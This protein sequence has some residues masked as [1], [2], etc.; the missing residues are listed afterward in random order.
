MI[1][2]ID[3]DHRC[4]DEGEEKLMEICKP[5]WPTRYLRAAWA[6]CGL[7]ILSS[8]PLA[9]TQGGQ[10][11][12]RPEA[13]ETI[14]L[15]VPDV[16]AKSPEQ[17][18]AL[19]EAIGLFNQVLWEDLKFSGYF[20]MAGKSFY[21]PTP[22]TGPEDLD[23]DAWKAIPFSV[24]YTSVG[25]LELTGGILRAELRVV[26]ME[27]QAMAFGKAIRGDTDQVR[28]IAHRWADEV[29]YQLT[30]GESKGIA[31]TK[32]SYTAASGGAKEI[33]IMD[34]DGNDARTFTNNGSI[35]L[36]PHWSADNSKLAF[37]SLRTG[38]W[39]INL[40][41]YTT[42]A[43]LPF[44]I[45]NSFA[46]TPVVSPGGE[47]ILFSLRTPRGDT[48]LFVA[49]IDGS[50][51]RNIT[52]NPAIDTSPTWAPSGRQIAFI[53]GRSGVSQVYVA[54]I[55][56]ANV[57]RIIKEGGD[58]D[59]PVWSPNGRYLAFHW[60]PRRAVTYDIYI[61]EVASGEIIQITSDAGTNESPTWAPDSRHLAFESNRNGAR[62]IFVMLADGTETRM[63]TSEGANTSPSW[64][65][66]SK[67]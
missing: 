27:Q 10:I 6:L 18:G 22:I 62:Q 61:V 48:D 47:K 34:Y 3:T 15:A 25:S 49:N 41:S 24:N 19:A 36:F 4:S 66:Y 1:I 57:R 43:R 13:G 16:A 67:R 56:G 20:Q 35:N 38:R 54:D 9:V 29:V 26:D 53:S 59:S 45:F 7:V 58:A 17:Q 12:V 23:Y 5:S 32:I 30:A 55:D 40:H 63:V 21:P 51:R 8:P 14:I 64:S 46:S 65:G 11:V 42:G 33:A 31:A 50:D 39:E 37:V 2:C 44:P 28:A 60:K 52:N